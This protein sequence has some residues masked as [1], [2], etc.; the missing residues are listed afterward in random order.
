[1]S[2][3]MRK[4][5]SKEYYRLTGCEVLFD[6]YRTPYIGGISGVIVNASVQSAWW[7]WKKSREAMKPINLPVKSYIP[8]GH[9]KSDYDRGIDDAISMCE[10]SI[11]QAGYKVEE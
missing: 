1:M 3:E 6:D 2:E 7:G 11:K 8:V 5:F 10:E 4:D 9:Y